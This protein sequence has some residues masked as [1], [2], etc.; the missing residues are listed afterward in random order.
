[1][2]I[3]ARARF[4]EK[5]SR[6]FWKWGCPS[7]LKYCAFLL[8]LSINAVK[9]EPSNQV[10]DVADDFLKI[11]QS[12][13]YGND[14]APILK[15]DRATIN[16]IPIFGGNETTEFSPTFT[17]TFEIVSNLVVENTEIAIRI[18][19]EPN[20]EDAHFLVLY[21]TPEELPILALYLER[22]LGISEVRT[23]LMKQRLA[24]RP[25]CI[26]YINSAGTNNIGFTVVTIER[27]EY[28]R[29]CIYEEFLHGLGLTGHTIDLDGAILGSNFMGLG[30]TAKD[31]VFLR[32]LYD[33]RIVSGE[34]YLP[35]NIIEVVRS[36]IEFWED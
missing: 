23:E 28:E 35:N 21:G 11:T 4:I 10:Y 14:S 22:S 17:S 2:W 24:L 31:E 9:S 12:D 36:Y 25:Q 15:W 16:V 7:L 27:G 34:I 6:K 3:A 32:M 30:P 33:D 20:L 29:A 19:P 18:E 1:M 26:T 5:L 13:G 8:F